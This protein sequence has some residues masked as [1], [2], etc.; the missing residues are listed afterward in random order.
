MLNS[1]ENMGQIT[2]DRHHPRLDQGQED[3]GGD[4][5]PLETT[6]IRLIRRPIDC[7]QRSLGRG[8]R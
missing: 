1:Y 7:R 6:D 2:N 3:G 5:L 8:R 4:R